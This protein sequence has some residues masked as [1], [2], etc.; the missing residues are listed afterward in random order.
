[1]PGSNCLVVIEALVPKGRK[2]HDGA[3][4]NERCHRRDFLAAGSGPFFR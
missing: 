3:A 4:Q 2:A 1:M